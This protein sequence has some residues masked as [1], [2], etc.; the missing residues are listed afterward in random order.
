DTAELVARQEREAE[1]SRKAAIASRLADGRAALEAGRLGPDIKDG[2]IDAFRAVLKLDPGNVDARKGIDAVAQAHLDIAM[3][4]IAA[5]EFDAARARIDTVAGID[6]GATGLV[7]VRNRLG[8]AERSAAERAERIRT[9]LAA[10]NKAIAEGRLAPPERE[11]AYNAYRS[12]LQVDP[13]NAQA[14][15][16]VGQVLQAL[17]KRG[18]SATQA[19][20]FA[21][22][23]QALDAMASIDAAADGLAAARTALEGAR[24]AALEKQQAERARL[25]QIDRLL[26]AAELDLRAG[27]IAAPASPNAAD[28]YREVLALDSGNAAAQAGLKRVA[29]QLL[30]QAEQAIRSEK[31]A[32]A[33]TL[34]EAAAAIDARAD[35]LAGARRTLADARKALDRRE[36]E[37]LARQERIDRLLGSADT[38]LR[39][40]RLSPPGRDNALDGYRAVLELDAGNARA[41]AGIRAVAAAELT[42]GREAIAAGDL[43]KARTALKSAEGIDASVDGLSDTRRIL[44]DAER[45]Q[46]ERQAR[47]EAE[48]AERQA[49]EAEARRAAE[50]RQAAAEQQA[51]VARLVERGQQALAAKRLTTPAGNN[52]LALFRQALE[53]DPS[54]QGAQDGLEAIVAAYR[55]L[56]SAALDRNDPGRAEDYIARAT[57]IAPRG[58]AIADMRARLAAW[59]DERQAREAREREARAQAEAEAARVAAERERLEAARRDEA[60]RSQAGRIDSL[61]SRANAAL[62]ADRLTQPRDDNALDGFRTVLSL[63]PGNEAAE[64]GINQVAERYVTLAARATRS[65]ELDAAGRYLDSASQVRPG[66]ASITLARESLAQARGAAARDAASREAAAREA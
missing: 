59:R 31:L 47:A 8:A 61:L 28:R 52:A 50:A 34:L 20:D 10:G 55:D 17:L 4:A 14:R 48:A 46:A 37:A 57:D 25:E 56:A 38:A 40:G 36:A 29:G 21:L 64:R 44:A 30:A 51:R 3:K 54:S 12:V 24:Q 5:G 23:A 26:A 18:Q 16:G 19:G 53:L 13:D 6:A 62:A 33:G 2:A 39:A 65:G 45:A 43:D 66:L 22:A 9:D 60:Q 58:A 7:S 1:A 11:S 49:R 42:R 27:R 41:L 32:D 63:D 15:A 35:G